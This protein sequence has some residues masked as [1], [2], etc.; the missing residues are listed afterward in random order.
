MDLGLTMAVGSASQIGLVLAPLL[1]IGSYV[2]GPA[3]MA[4]VFNGWEVVALLAAAVI[5]AT[6]T[7]DGESTWLEG[8]E[9]LAVYILLGVFFYFA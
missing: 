9:L 2:I 3:P 5:T 1:V 4:L 6:L 8:I 7:S